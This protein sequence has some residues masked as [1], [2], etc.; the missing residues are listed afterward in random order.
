MHR[1]C[2]FVRYS[3]EEQRSSGACVKSKSRNSCNCLLF[4]VPREVITYLRAGLKVPSDGCLG[5]SFTI[6]KVY[7]SRVPQERNWESNLLRC[8]YGSLSFRRKRAD[9]VQTQLTWK[10]VNHQVG[11]LYLKLDHPLGNVES[12]SKEIPILQFIASK[13]I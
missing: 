3:Q 9:V 12:F 5:S 8:V 4:S 1:F 13:C 7:D 6:F 10:S 11:V 2:S